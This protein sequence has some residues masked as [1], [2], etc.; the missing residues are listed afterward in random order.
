MMLLTTA[1]ALSLIR[2]H[3]LGSRVLISDN[4]S[5]DDKYEVISTHVIHPANQHLDIPA[6]APT[7]D[8]EA[9]IKLMFASFSN[10]LEQSMRLAADVHPDIQ[11]L[12]L[13]LEGC[14]NV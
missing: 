8:P 5:W 7:G 6:I 13:E 2:I 11:D 9:D 10:A 14:R 4:A 12:L 3:A 1:S